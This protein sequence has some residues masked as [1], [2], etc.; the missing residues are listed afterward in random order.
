MYI[1]PCTRRPTIFW[2]IWSCTLCKLLCGPTR[3]HELLSRT[4]IWNLSICADSIWMWRRCPQFSTCCGN[5]SRPI[6]N[7]LNGWHYMGQDPRFTL[8]RIEGGRLYKET[9]WGRSR[10]KLYSNN[11]TYYGV[12]IMLCH[13]NIPNV[14][15]QNHVIENHVFILA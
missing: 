13:A 6:A 11:W 10:F 15:L 2:S 5:E 3:S 9:S 12:R 7:D 4:D 1:E 8:P 14:F